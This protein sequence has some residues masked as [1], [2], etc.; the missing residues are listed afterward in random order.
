MPEV[1]DVRQDWP[2]LFLEDFILG[3]V[4]ETDSRTVTADDIQAFAELTGDHNPLHTDPEFAAASPFGRIIGH[5]LLGISILVGLFEDVGIFSGTALAFL[6]IKDWNFLAPIFAGDTLRAR[7]TVEGVRRSA[8]DPSRGIVT[9]RYEL[10][11]QD[12]TLVQSGITTVLLR[13]R[14]SG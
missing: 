8:S 14:T 11:N 9:R 12:D 7:M 2:G 10:F 4:F 5:G 6:G 13:A 3:Q 1:A